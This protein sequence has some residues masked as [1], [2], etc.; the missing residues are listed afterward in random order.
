MFQ[1]KLRMPFAAGRLPAEAPQL[2]F[3][4]CQ[5]ALYFAQDTSALSGYL[6]RSSHFY[7]CKGTFSPPRPFFFSTIPIDRRS[8]ASGSSA[9]RTFMLAKKGLAGTKG[10]FVIVK[11]EF[12]SFL[13]HMQIGTGSRAKNTSVIFVRQ[14]YMDQKYFELWGPKKRFFFRLI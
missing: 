11:W 9:A 5:R 8:C 14:D 13:W 2:A 1:R 7:A 12:R 4:R 3:L 6:L 10:L